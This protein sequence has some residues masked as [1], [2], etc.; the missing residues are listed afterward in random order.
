MVAVHVCESDRVPLGHGSI[1]GQVQGECY[2]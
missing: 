1:A 2:P